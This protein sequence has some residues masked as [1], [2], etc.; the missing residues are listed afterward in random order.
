MKGYQFL[1]MDFFEMCETRKIYRLP[2]LLYIYLRG[3]YC[4]FQKPV[5]T[6][7]DHKTLKHLGITHPTLQKCRR[8]LSEK[9]LLLY[10]SGNGLKNPTEYTLIGNVLLPELKVKNSFT[11][12]EKK[13]HLPLEKLSPSMI[14]SNER[15]KNRVGE[16]IFK[17][18][19]KDER[20]NLLT[21]GIFE[22]KTILKSRKAIY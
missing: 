11:K 14:T 12:G 17:G 6:W 7:E 21:N 15:L 22:S 18:M 5:F 10:K 20:I 13:L 1:E 16:E 3:L 2:Q 9:G 4:R 19:S 8:I